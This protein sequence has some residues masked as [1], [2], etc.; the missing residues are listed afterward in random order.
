MDPTSR[1][2]AVAGQPDQKDAAFLKSQLD[3]M[4]ATGG[5]MYLYDLSRVDQ[6]VLSAVEVYRYPETDPRAVADQK[7]APAMKEAGL[8]PV[9]GTTDLPA[10]EAVTVTGRADTQGV[11]LTSAVALLT[12]GPSVVSLTATFADPTAAQVQ[13]VL[14]SVQAA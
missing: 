4:A 12:L 1:Q 14:A 3:R 11:A 6:G 5:V 9:V 8:A 2:A 10:G 7:I 13:A